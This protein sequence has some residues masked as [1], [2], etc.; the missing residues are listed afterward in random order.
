MQKCRCIYHKTKHLRFPITRCTI[1]KLNTKLNLTLLRA[2]Q[3]FKSICL[4]D[5][6][7][8]RYDQQLIIFCKNVLS[9]KLPH[10]AP[11]TRD[12]VE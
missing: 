7:V 6:G 12:A 3:S 4:L 10:Q 11:E 2:V 1:T 5:C 9:I 8:G